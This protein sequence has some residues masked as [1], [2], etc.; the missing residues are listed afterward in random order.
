[1]PGVLLYNCLKGSVVYLIVL[2]VHALEWKGKGSDWPGALF[3][4]PLSNE[5]GFCFCLFCFSLSL[6]GQVTWCLSFLDLPWEMTA[7]CTGAVALLLKALA[8]KPEDLSSN[9]RT[10]L[11]QGENW[12]PQVLFWPNSVYSLSAWAHFSESWNSSLDYFHPILFLFWVK[13][14]HSFILTTIKSNPKTLWRQNCVNC[15][16]LC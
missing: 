12:L 8:T 13:I 10:H 16:L 14:T 9:P 4:S 2:C 1:M 7:H 6:K 3:A 15:N 5:L 11:V